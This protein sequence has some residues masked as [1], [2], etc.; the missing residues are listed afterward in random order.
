MQLYKTFLNRTREIQI[1][2]FPASNLDRKQEIG[3]WKRNNCTEN[4]GQILGVDRNSD[5][6]Q[7]APLIRIKVKLSWV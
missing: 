4:V 5:T 3:T 6:S 7:W 2:F 1:F